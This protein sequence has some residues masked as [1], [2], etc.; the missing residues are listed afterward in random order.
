MGRPPTINRLELLATAR[1]VFAEKGFDAAT[2]AD[3]AKELK[4]TPAAVLRHFPSKRAL[5]ETA[6]HTQT[7]P[8]PFILDIADVDASADPRVVLRQLAEQ[9]IPFAQRRGFS[10]ARCSHTFSCTTS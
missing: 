8:P 3:I 2:L 6:L 4:V 9:F 5:F 7:E 1:R 10:W